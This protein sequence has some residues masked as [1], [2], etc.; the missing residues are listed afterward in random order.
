MQ[1]DTFQQHIHAYETWKTTLSQGI[2]QFQTWLDE[3]RLG[4]PHDALPLYEALQSLRADRLTIAF[5]GEFSRGKSELINAIFFADQ[6]RR[7]LPTDAGRTTMCP[8]ELLH[9]PQ[10][11]GA[12][13]RL[14]PIETR[15]SAKSIA[16]HK[17]QPLKWN[18]IPLNLQSPD[19]MA[20][21]LREVL[22]VKQVSVDEAKRLGLYHDEAVLL[23]SGLVEIPHWRHAVI[24]FPHPLLK[25]GLVVLDTPG[26]NALGNE[27]ELTMQMLPAAQA[28]LFVLGADTGVTR[29][30]LAMWRQ[31]FKGQR[32]RQ[33]GML[34]ALNKIDT[35]WDELTD[36]ASTAAVINAQQRSCAEQLGIDSASV[37]PV[38]AQKALVAKVRGDAPLLA[39]S[40]LPE[41]E[42]YLCEEIIPTRQQIV[43]ETVL[44]T[45]DARSQ[46]VRD[47]LNG[48]VQQLDRHGDELRTLRG[49][50]ADAVLQLMTETRSEQ[51]RYLK[52]VEN[53]QTGRNLVTG[54]GRLLL[55]TL[56]P[57]ALDQL[58]AQTR[59]SMV[60]S[61]TTLGLKHAMA[62][63]FETTRANLQEALS[64][65]E[66]LQR[67]VQNSYRRFHEEHGL[68]QLHPQTL[69]L[70]RH[71][72]DLDELYQDA[73][74]YRGSTLTTMTEQGFVIEKFFSTLVHEVREIFARAH[75]TAQSWLGA[76]LNPLQT[77]IREHQQMTEQRLETLRKISQSRDILEL[78][79]RE[80]ERQRQHLQGQLATLQSLRAALHQPPPQSQPSSAGNV[81]PLRAAG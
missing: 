78:K 54:Q 23:P 77:Q 27:P 9:D 61:W 51:T 80:L 32:Q 26:L 76:V 50:S 17:L 18:S 39:N 31:L 52:S 58:S 46:A 20:K 56:D 38:S 11:S 22:R 21:A 60:E 65:A 45:V 25:Q 10:A 19:Q 57:V 6:G 73:E 36:P 13:I 62:N 75:Q 30:D 33:S 74:E 55:D 12:Y 3:Q 34:V 15:T 70:H 49:Q 66:Q 24:N 43:H 72:M 68:A 7:L 67:V 59:Q 71:F 14:L 8:T 63:F 5:M 44:T 1:E 79:L 69:A 35:L 64:L 48:R 37:F 41:L 42:R 81:T 47:L 4:T 28:V 2:E 53:F 29:S 40:R 16:D